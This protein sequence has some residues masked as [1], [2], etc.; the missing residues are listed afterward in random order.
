MVNKIWSIFTGSIKLTI[1]VLTCVFAYS[2][3]TVFDKRVEQ[4]IENTESTNHDPK[5]YWDLREYVDKFDDGTGK[6]YITN[7]ELIKGTFDN[8]ATQNAPLFVSF[9]ISGNDRVTLA[10][11]EYK[12]MN[13]VRTIGD[14]EYVLE[15]KKP[16][17][18]TE[19][20]Y[21]TLYTDRLIFSEAESNTI[22]KILSSGGELKFFL[23]DKEYGSVE[24]RFKMQLDDEYVK[25]FEELKAKNGLSEDLKNEL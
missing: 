23:T 1:I 21:P 19:M 14:K 13:E 20:F 17:N 3:M 4:S 9:V 15:L 7:K 24:Y 12:V 16:D 18:T 10:L 22:H 5:I 25:R 8:V 6:F 2:C 11:Y